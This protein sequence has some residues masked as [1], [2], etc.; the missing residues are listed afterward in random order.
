M[1][2]ECFITWD[3]FENEF[4]RELDWVIRKFLERVTCGEF[5]DNEWAVLRE[6][7]KPSLFEDAETLHIGFN[8]SGEVLAKVNKALP[9]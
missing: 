6:G 5:T 2:N 3:N 4:M 8:I 7:I 1:E 9:K